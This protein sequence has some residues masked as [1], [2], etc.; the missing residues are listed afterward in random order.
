MELQDT[1]PE[2]VEVV[3]AVVAVAVV[4]ASSRHRGLRNLVD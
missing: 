4:A 3:E 2:V 1:F